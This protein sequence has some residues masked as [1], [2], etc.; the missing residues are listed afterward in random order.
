[1]NKRL[2][3]DNRSLKVRSVESFQKIKQKSCNY[4]NFITHNKI[5]NHKMEKPSLA[6]NDPS[7]MESF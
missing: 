2:I 6:E 1:M 7:S 5:L 3:F 4:I